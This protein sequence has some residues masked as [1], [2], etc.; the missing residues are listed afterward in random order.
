MD[1]IKAQ[2]ILDRYLNDEDKSS[3]A[4]EYGFKTV[5]ALVAFKRQQLDRN[6]DSGYILAGDEVLKPCSSVPFYASNL[7]NLFNVH[8]Q[9]IMLSD[10][11]RGYLTIYANKRTLLVHR[12]IC[13][14]F[15][16]Q[17]EK[18][19]NHIDGNK[20]NNRI[21]N[22]E[23]CTA[24]ENVTHSI[25]TL[26]NFKHGEYNGFSKLTDEKV[27][28]IYLSYVPRSQEYGLMGLAEKYDVDYTTIHLIVKRKI[29]A[30]AT[31]D[32]PPIDTSKGKLSDEA[33]VDIVE[34]YE[35]R[36]D[37]NVKFFCKKYGVSSPTIKKVLDRLAVNWFIRGLRTAIAVL[38][39]AFI[40]TL[41][42]SKP[43]L[44]GAF[45]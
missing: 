38:V 39:V 5:W 20:S 34:N 23:Y 24:Q 28:E 19:V 32:L 30:H 2:T 21:V 12:L 33:I 18:Q 16:G 4:K 6:I 9:R 35:W 36:G 17:S 42:H 14:A 41:T 45:E 31:K 37:K 26:G 3:L 43:A 22:L 25:E 29:W 8:K 15:Y 27:R 7:G 11:H 1:L 40:L 13:E 10:R 44:F